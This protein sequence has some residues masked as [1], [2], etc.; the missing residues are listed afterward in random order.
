MP[1]LDRLRKL[2]GHIVTGASSP[3]AATA[4]PLAV[5]GTVGSGMQ[6]STVEAL[7]IDRGRITGGGGTALVFVK[8]VT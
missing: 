3:M 8:I 1:A 7:H 5:V 6:I 4:S 2:N